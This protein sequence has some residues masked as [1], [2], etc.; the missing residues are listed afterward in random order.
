MRSIIQHNFT[1]GL[2]DCLVAITEYL[3]TTKKLKQLGYIVDLKL[4]LNQNS[5][6]DKNDFFSIYNESKFT[7]FNSIEFLDSPITDLCFLSL[8]IVYT[9]SN[10]NP[11]MHWCD[12]YV[13]ENNFDTNLISIFPYYSNNLPEKIE[14]LNEKV[15]YGF[16]FIKEKYVSTSFYS[17]IYIRTFDQN[18]GHDYFEN[19]KEKIIEIIKNNNIVLVCSNSFN[20]KK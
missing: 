18:D 6:I 19:I 4:N 17:S 8:N 7:I 12:L 20:V 16:N 14:I 3:E 1:S 13:S 2:G 11:G 5:Y 10:A 15:I 9:I